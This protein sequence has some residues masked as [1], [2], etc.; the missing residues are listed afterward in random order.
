[1][2]ALGALE[3]GRDWVYDQVKTLEVGREAILGAMSSLE[4]V[5]GGDGAMY[6]MGKLPDGV[7]D[8]VKREL[9]CLHV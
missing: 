8:Q 7:D 3:A 2:A 6:V 1:M 9:A 4:E 5:I